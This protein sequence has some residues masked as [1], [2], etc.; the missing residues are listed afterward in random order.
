[1][2]QLK[3]VRDEKEELRKKADST[4]QSAHDAATAAADAARAI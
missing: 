1:V 2:E 3:K 4:M